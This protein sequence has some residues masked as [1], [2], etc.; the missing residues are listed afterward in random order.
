MEITEKKQILTQYNSFY[1]YTLK[2]H[3]TGFARTTV[4]ALSYLMLLLFDF[5]VKFLSFDV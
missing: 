1:N 5:D 4:A 2:M 3:Q